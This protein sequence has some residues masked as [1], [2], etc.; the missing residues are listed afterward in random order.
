MKNHPRGF[1]AGVG[2]APAHKAGVERINST[3]QQAIDA[4]NAMRPHVSD[5]MMSAI[6]GAPANP[7]AEAQDFGSLFPRAAKESWN[8]AGM[9]GRVM[10]TRMGTNH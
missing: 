1:L 5:D 3:T 2:G 7:T 8:T 10:H 9:P 6:G 4:R